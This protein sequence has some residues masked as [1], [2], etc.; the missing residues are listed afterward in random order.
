MTAA[1]T[2][3][4]RRRG[5]GAAEADLAAETASAVYRVACRRW[6]DADGDLDLRDLE[7]RKLMGK[8]LLAIT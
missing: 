5:I 1:L 4:L 7:A 3:G 8:A 2:D 6:V